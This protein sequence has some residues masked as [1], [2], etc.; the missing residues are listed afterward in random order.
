M[1]KACFHA[2]QKMWLVIGIYYELVSKLESLS[3]VERSSYDVGCEEN[4]VALLALV[5]E[6]NYIRYVVGQEV[7]W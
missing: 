4:Y 5:K 1:I 3:I 2:R 6:H 7:K